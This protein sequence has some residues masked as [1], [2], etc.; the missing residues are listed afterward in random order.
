[1]VWDGQRQACARECIPSDKDITLEIAA[2]KYAASLANQVDWAL[3]LCRQ[4]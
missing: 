2:L 4:A 1:M 3:H